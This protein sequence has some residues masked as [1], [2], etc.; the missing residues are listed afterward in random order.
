MEKPLCTINI[1][2]K[3]KI[4]R[5]DIQL[6]NDVAKSQRFIPRI[7]RKSLKTRQNNF[8]LCCLGSP[9]REM[10]AVGNH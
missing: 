1:H 5:A 10:D 4:K 8:R 6:Q 2:K 3:N 7:I 9:D